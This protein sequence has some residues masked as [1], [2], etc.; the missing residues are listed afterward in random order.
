MLVEPFVC[1]SWVSRSTDICCAV[2][3]AGRG[4]DREYSSH[5]S[6]AITITPTTATTSAPVLWR[7]ASPRST[8]PLEGCERG[9]AAE[10]CDD[11]AA[12]LWCPDEPTVALLP[13]P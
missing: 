11:E 4:C 2:V 13:V 3:R 10:I 8:C 9:C 6:A 1:P 5:P 12:A 7:L